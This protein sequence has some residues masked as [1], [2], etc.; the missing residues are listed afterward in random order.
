MVLT[1]NP[2]PSFDFRTF[3]SEEIERRHREKN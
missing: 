2:L 1:P 3:V